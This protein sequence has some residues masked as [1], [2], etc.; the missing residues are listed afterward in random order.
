MMQRIKTPMTL[1]RLIQ[2]N[3]ACS[4]ISLSRTSVS[5]VNLFIILPIGVVSKKAIGANIILLKQVIFKMVD[6]RF[7][8]KTMVQNCQIAHKTNIIVIIT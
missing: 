2:V 4:A 5:L 3:L 1:P 7:A 8:M 6:A